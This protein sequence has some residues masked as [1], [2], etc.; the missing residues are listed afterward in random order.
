[1]D[2]F[3]EFIEKIPVLPTFHNSHHMHSLTYNILQIAHKV[4]TLSE[5]S[6]AGE[7]EG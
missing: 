6:Q 3:L 7:G 1:M 5:I 4:I 2:E